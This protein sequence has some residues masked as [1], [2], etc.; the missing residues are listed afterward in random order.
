MKQKIYTTEE[1]LV[2][3][4]DQRRGLAKQLRLYHK[5]IG[6]VPSVTPYH[7]TSGLQHS[8]SGL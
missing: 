8:N 6:H 1:A 4:M 3:V 2:K 5:V 7:D